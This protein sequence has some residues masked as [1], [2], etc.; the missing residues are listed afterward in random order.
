MMKSNTLTA[1]QRANKRQNKIRL[2]KEKIPTIALDDDLAEMMNALVAI[3]GSK[4]AV[5][6]EGVRKLYELNVS[7]ET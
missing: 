5:V 3:Y 6:K 7:V 4:S 2:G 1:Q